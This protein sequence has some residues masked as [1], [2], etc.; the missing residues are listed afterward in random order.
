M[1]NP[2]YVVALV[3]GAVMLLSVC[4]V[5]VKHQILQLGGI[6]LSGF[7]VVLVGMSVWR[8]IDVSVDENGFKAKLEQAIAAAND[9]KA[10][11]AQVKEISSKNSEAALALKEAVEAFKTQDALRDMGLY[12]GALDGHFGATTKKSILEFQ[13]LK[14]IPKTGILDPKTIEELKIKPI[15]KFPQLEKSLVP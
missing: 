7:A 10:Q 2:A 15:Q 5:Y 3:L 8:S 13:E 14:N 1:E 9:A 12:K 11:V 4:F 6:S